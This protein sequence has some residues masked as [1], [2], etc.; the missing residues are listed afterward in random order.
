M[1][2]REQQI[3]SAERNIARCVINR[4]R[5]EASL[6]Q[7]QAEQADADSDIHAEEVSR[8]FTCISDWTQRIEDE[9][10][11]LDALLSQGEDL[12]CS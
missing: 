12:H 1:V 4:R 10:A 7:L 6:R 8:L 5:D 11:K 3:H 9:A 2:T